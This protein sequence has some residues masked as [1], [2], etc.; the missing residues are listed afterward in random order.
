MKITISGYGK[1]GMEIERAALN[2][3]HEVMAK[4]DVASDWQKN[5]SLVK[6]S[7]VAI[8]F[9]TPGSVVDNIRRCF[10]LHLPVVVGTTGWNEKIETVKKW[11]TDENQSL[12]FASNFS[13][14]INVLN[15]LT[16]HLAEIIDQFENYEVAIEEIHHIHKLDAPSGTAIKLAEI[17]LAGIYRKKQW[18]NHSQAH[19]EELQVL[20]VREGEIPGIHTIT[21]ESDFDKLVLRH[22]AKG[23]QGFA[24]GALLAAEWLKGKAGFFGMNDLL[25]FPA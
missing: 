17:I 18:V 25:R 24:I 7:D 22:E 12:F 4:L 23:R 20:S 1:M 11:C 14:G 10:D 2:R 15:S 13:I 8:D 21:C 16:G 9:S 6:R 19:P 3:G 5:M